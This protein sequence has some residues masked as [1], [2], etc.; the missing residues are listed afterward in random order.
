MSTGTVSSGRQSSHGTE[1]VGGTYV[2]HDRASG[3]GSE[4]ESCWTVT[5]AGGDGPGKLEFQ[6]RLGNP[7]QE[8]GL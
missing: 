3:S 2:T 6:V 5:P 4:L 1:I 7:S 8:S